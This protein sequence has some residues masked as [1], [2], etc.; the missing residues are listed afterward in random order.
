[1]I[2][3]FKDLNALYAIT[4][5]RP[6]T[7]L[8]SE[9]GGQKDSTFYLQVSGYPAGSVLTVA[10]Q[11]TDLFQAPRF[12]IAVKPAASAWSLTIPN[13]PF[14]AEL[15]SSGLYPVSVRAKA[16][17]GDR[18]EA[19]AWSIRV[20]VIHN[21]VAVDSY[22]IPGSLVQATQSLNLRYRLL[23]SARQIQP[24]LPGFV[25]GSYRW[26]DE[27]STNAH[28]LV[29]TDWTI[30]PDAIG[31][32]KFIAGIGFDD[33]LEF[34]RLVRDDHSIY[35][36]IHHG[37]YFT[38]PDRY[39]CPS[40]DGVL[41]VIRVSEG[42]LT[43]TLQKSPVRGK[44]V[45]VGTYRE[46]AQ[47][48]YDTDISYRY[49]GHGLQT[50]DG[51]DPDDA[52]FQFKLN[53][54]TKTL[55][56]NKAISSTVAYG[57]TVPLETIVKVDLPVFPMWDVVRVYVENANHPVSV[58]NLD[59]V[60]GT[61]TLLFPANMFGYSYYFEYVPALAIFYEAE[62]EPDPTVVDLSVA[63][64]GE[65]VL[66]TA[67]LNPAFSGLIS[68]TVYLIHRRL[69]AKELVLYADKPRINVP[70][71]LLSIVGLV[72]YGPVYYENDFALLLAQA[73][74]NNEQEMV[75]NV[76]LRMIV[77]A[78]FEGLINYQDPKTDLVEVVT[79]GDGLAAFVYSPPKAFGF[80]LDGATSITNDTVTL[81]EPLPFTQLWNVDDGW[82]VRFY[83]VRD[84][85]PL[86]GSVT[87]NPD[88]GEIPW[89]T[90]GY[91]GSISYQTNG[92]RFQIKD[93]GVPMLPVN[94][95]DSAGTPAFTEQGAPNSGFNGTAQTLV[96]PPGS[97]PKDSF[98]GAYYMT[99]IGRA[100]IQVQDE[101]SGL[102]SNTILLQLEPAPEIHDISPVNGYLYL[103][104][105]EDVRQGFINVNR[106]G[107]ASLKDV[108]YNTV[109]Y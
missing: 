20:T 27:N 19:H 80:Y 82:V 60:N 16:L 23:P 33:D 79:G 102:I 22:D 85:N 84:D 95:Y 73:T 72:A 8:V 67:D 24:A 51:F 21:A 109:R 69:Q 88:Y 99:F 28:V 38:G 91:P 56:L 47:G 45:Y 94:A 63:Q 71:T 83:Y 37:T 55:T 43:I 59:R 89:T 12:S 36:V 93:N 107:G 7:L 10:P 40:K 74:G 87:A 108:I 105:D 78:D 34:R 31:R 61:A 52:G 53:R 57:G 26:R 32:E 76:R 98:I 15:P 65:R 70:A 13:T 44:I 86:F 39:F 29:P 100:Q 104:T 48:Y 4:A 9:D 103:D 11:G 58:F 106:L 96:Y 18:H 101:D 14:L 35:P 62:P 64:I 49:L 42:E 25:F 6:L 81:P 97:I 92:Q 46:D 50:S 54:K 30:D 75:P 41:E 3:A 66:K 2:Q 77:G 17:P 90:S 1:M 68:G 5:L